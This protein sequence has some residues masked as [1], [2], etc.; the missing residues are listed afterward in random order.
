MPAFVGAH[1][2]Q[3][4]S[5]IRET[6]RDQSSTPFFTARAF[7][8]IDIVLRDRIRKSALRPLVHTCDTAGGRHH[9]PR[10]ARAHVQRP[11]GRLSRPRL[12]LDATCRVPLPCKLP[13]LDLPSV[14]VHFSRLRRNWLWQTMQTTHVSVSHS[15]KGSP[16]QR[17]FPHF[18]FL[19][20]GQQ[21][22]S[23]ALETK[24]HWTEMK[25][26]SVNLKSNN[27]KIA[28]SYFATLDRGNKFC[29]C[30]APALPRDHL[31]IGVFGPDYHMGL[32]VCPEA[33]VLSDGTG[34]GR[35]IL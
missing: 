8:T 11:T 22:F 18:A 3:R 16:I 14:S 24:L 13:S 4:H 20:K 7:D 28:R 12:A 26:I 5:I 6:T 9:R 1:Q 21:Y 17:H 25:A 35:L 15:V 29:T 33:Q 27:Q 31:R 23:T 10:N 19:K 32:S 34:A 30:R 2:D